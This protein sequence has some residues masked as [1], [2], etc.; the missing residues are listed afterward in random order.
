MTP[1]DR[2][3]LLH[4]LDAIDRI[5]RYCDGGRATL[6]D[7]MTGDAV[8]HCLTVIGEALG[9]LTAEMYSRLPSLPPHLPKG[10]RNIL[11]H[12]YWRV[13]LDVVWNTVVQEL[14]P[15]RADIESLLSSR[16]DSSG[17]EGGRAV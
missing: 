11:V 8:L 5:H 15:L 14:P 16:V 4:V 3:R 2:R 9:S 12:E 10:Q 13:D 1:A 7:D 6:D 17:R